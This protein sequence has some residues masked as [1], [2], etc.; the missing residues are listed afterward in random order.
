MGGISHGSGIVDL[1]YSS[2][3]FKLMWVS[4]VMMYDSGGDCD[5]VLVL[6]ICLGLLFGFRF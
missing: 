1:L 6:Y 4:L 3:L 2:L 5:L